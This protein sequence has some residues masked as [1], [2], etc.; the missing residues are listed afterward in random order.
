MRAKDEIKH[1]FANIV[2]MIGNAPNLA[3]PIFL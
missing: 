2:S 3:I 1:K